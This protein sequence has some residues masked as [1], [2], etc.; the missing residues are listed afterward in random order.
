MALEVPY[1]HSVMYMAMKQFGGISYKDLAAMLFAPDFAYG[2]V[3][4]RERLQERTFVTRNV[5][6]AE[7]GRFTERNYVNLPQLAERIGSILLSKHQGKEGRRLIGE[8]FAQEACDDMCASLLAMGASDALYRNIVSRISQMELS[9]DAD[10][11]AL[12]VLQFVATGCLDDPVRAADIT[13]ERSRQIVDSSFRTSI[14]REGD[15]ALAPD[16]DDPVQLGLCRVVGGKLIMPVH[17]L[18]TDDLGTEIGALSTASHAIN[19][20]DETVS[21][22]H[23]RVFRDE[24]GHWLVEGLGST[25][26]TF[27][28]RGDTKK[29]EVVEPPKADRQPGEA[30]PPARIHPSDLLCLGEATQ[31]MVVALA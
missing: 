12:L 26:G 30:H 15:N 14:A 2:G 5:V 1:P 13:M 7:P 3:P 19:D 31:F 29:R 24:Q 9:R 4:M 11:V 16:D 8:Y 10:K 23:A 22:R 21:K 18:A 25:N 17:A 6:H 28:V 20:V 27:V